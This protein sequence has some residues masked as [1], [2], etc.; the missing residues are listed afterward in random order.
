[1]PTSLLTGE[2]KTDSQTLSGKTPFGVAKVAQREGKPII[3]ISGVIDEKGRECISSLFTEL[4]EIADGTVSPEDSI[5]NAIQL[6]AIKNEEDD[7]ELFR[8][9]KDK[10]VLRCYLQLLHLV[11]C[12]LYC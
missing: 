7:G 10:G 4:H 6:F 5:K 11:L 12:S 3:L 8:K 2:G 9:T 1:M